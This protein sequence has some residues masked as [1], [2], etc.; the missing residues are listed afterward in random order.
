MLKKVEEKFDKT[1]KAEYLV[2]PEHLQDFIQDSKKYFADLEERLDEPGVKDSINDKNPNT[3]GKTAFDAYKTF[4]TDS[5]EGVFKELKEQ[6]KTYETEY[7]EYHKKLTKVDEV[8]KKL[9]SYDTFKASKEPSD[10]L[11]S[12][13][14][15]VGN[16]N[17]AK[18]YLKKR[19]NSL[20]HKIDAYVILQ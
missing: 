9:K 19:I 8:A 12:Q 18:E 1:R 20:N 2:S 14:S 16:G 4:L 11:K 13:L 17:I 6:F 3:G 15:E 5:V 10:G 7:E